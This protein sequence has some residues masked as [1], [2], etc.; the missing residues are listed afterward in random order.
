MKVCKC[1]LSENYKLS[2]CDECGKYGKMVYL[3][4]DVTVYITEGSD[5]D[6]LLDF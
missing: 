1:E 6:Y 3:G 5:L 2:K 4:D